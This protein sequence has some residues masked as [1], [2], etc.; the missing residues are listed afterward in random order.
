MTVLKSKLMYG[1]VHYM[2]QLTKAAEACNKS[3][4]FGW[5]QKCSWHFP[6]QLPEKKVMFNVWVLDKHLERFKAFKEKCNRSKAIIVR[7]RWY[8]WN[9][10]F[11]LVSSMIFL[12]WFYLKL[13]QWM[14]QSYP[15]HVKMTIL[16]WYLTFN[17]GLF[18]VTNIT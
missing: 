7:H 17:E 2:N 4:Y 11:P 1:R 9:R 13:T 18:Y 10:G 5:S 6:K 8:E 14:Y 16:K 3:V 12:F 15:L